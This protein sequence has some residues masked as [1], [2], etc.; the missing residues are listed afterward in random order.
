MK[1]VERKLDSVRKE[2]EGAISIIEG[3]VKKSYN[4]FKQ[5]GS[6]QNTGF[7]G[8]RTYG[9]MASG[10]AI[11]SSDVDLS[12]TGIDFK[13]NREHLIMEMK[14]LYEQLEFMKSKSSIKFIE[15]ATVPIIKLQIDL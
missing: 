11:D 1:E 12:V 13:G 3:I 8:I 4:E 10:L 15:T 9:S 5:Y 14:A 2:R 7:V 6:P